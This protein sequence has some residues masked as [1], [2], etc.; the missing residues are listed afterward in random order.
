MEK[1]RLVYDATELRNGFCGDSGR[2]GLFSVALNALRELVRRDDVDLTLT[3]KFSD[4]AYVKYVLNQEFRKVDFNFEIDCKAFVFYSQLKLMKRLA[5]NNK[6]SVKKVLLQLL[7]LVIS[8]ICKLLS[9]FV[10]KNTFEEFNAFLSPVFSIS[11][12]IK[13]KKYTVL[14]DLIPLKFPEYRSNDWKS[15][16]WLYDLCQSLNSNDYYFTVSENT[17]GDFLKCYPQIDERKIKT[18]LPS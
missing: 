15:G 11:Q 13:A 9:F 6:E 1:L 7:C 17:R 12:K 2:S 5:T 8:P 3:C 10:K 16:F 14:H 18:I 4:Y